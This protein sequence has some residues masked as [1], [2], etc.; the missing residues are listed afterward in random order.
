MEI[1]GGAAATIKPTW[2]DTGPGAL[3]GGIPRLGPQAERSSAWV[4]R[5]GEVKPPT[6]REVCWCVALALEGERER[7]AMK[8]LR[9]VGMRIVA[10]MPP[11]EVVAVVNLVCVV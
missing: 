4:N 6:E 11:T 8:C 7:R 10:W 3:A 9:T 5:D 1:G 2:P